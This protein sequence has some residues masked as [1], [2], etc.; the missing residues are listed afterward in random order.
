MKLNNF[1]TDLQLDEKSKISKIEYTWKRYENQEC[2]LFFYAFK[3]FDH[4]NI[5]IGRVQNLSDQ[6]FRR[7]ILRDGFNFKNKRKEYCFISKDEQ[8][9]AIYMSLRKSGSLISISFVLVRN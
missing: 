7:A 2:E 4:N 9:A 1:Q 5:E 3:F 6:Q 8:I